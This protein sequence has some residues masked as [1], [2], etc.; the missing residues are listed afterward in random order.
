VDTIH[1]VLAPE[2]SLARYRVRE[3]LASLSFPS[4]AVGETTEV[5][6]EI[7]I[8]ALGQVVPEVSTFTVNLDSLQSDRDLRDGF[9]RR[10][11]LQTDLFPLATFTAREARGL[12]SPL[13]T[14]G[15]VAFQLLGDLTLHGVTQE[16]LWEV[17][18]VVNGDNLTGT[19]STQ[20]TFNAFGLEIPRVLSVLS[21]DDLIRLELDFNLMRVP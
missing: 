10:N 17:S 9:V 14:S 4:D 2:G 5:T 13:P 11:T 6:G 15:P 3:Q 12:A 20:F 7:T 1:L 18:G 16:S 19:A 21:V 8:T